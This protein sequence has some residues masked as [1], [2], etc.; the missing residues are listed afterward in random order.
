MQVA[1]REA[2]LRLVSVERGWDAGGKRRRNSAAKK[3]HKDRQGHMTR[4]GVFLYFQSLFIRTQV[5]NS[6]LERKDK[7]TESHGD[8]H[9]E[10]LPSENNLDVLLMS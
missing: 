8:H 3:G 6:T 5:Q 1:E 4:R 10:F 2:W 7:E 9:Q